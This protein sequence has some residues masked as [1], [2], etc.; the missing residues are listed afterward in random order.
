MRQVTRWGVT[1]V[2][3]S[4]AIKVGLTGFGIAHQQ[5]GFREPFTANLLDPCM[6]KRGDILYLF[7][8][9]RRERRHAKGWPA[10]LEERS[11]SISIMVLKDDGAAQQVG[12]LFCTCRL[13]A[14]TERTT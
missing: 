11:Q 8:R 10:L 5:R 9:Q 12:R 1:G 2:A 4:P 3:F 14:M 7:R 6:Q 13:R